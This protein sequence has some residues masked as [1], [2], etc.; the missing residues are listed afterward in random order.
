MKNYYTTIE[1]SRRL[2]ELGLAQETADM[3]YIETPNKD[4]RITAYPIIKCAVL[5]DARGS[6]ANL[7]PSWSFGALFDILPDIIDYK[8]TPCDLEISKNWISYEGYDKYDSSVIVQ[9]VVMNDKPFMELLYWMVC[10]L[11][12]N[13][14][15]K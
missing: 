3:C 2:C 10:W 6:D 4:F 9:P 8:D 15:L 14:H 13:G 11:L 1:Q 5:R 12:E 7:Y